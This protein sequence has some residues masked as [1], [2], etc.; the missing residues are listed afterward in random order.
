LVIGTSKYKRI[1]GKKPRWKYPHNRA[2]SSPPR[3]RL[4]LV[5]RALKK[6]ERRR[7]GSSLLDF[8]LRLVP[9]AGVDDVRRVGMICL[10]VFFSVCRYW[11]M[12][13]NL[14]TENNKM[15]VGS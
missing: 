5:R 13:D 7:R 10:F 1:N 14:Q 2:E 6:D 8:L 9:A 4:C 12:Y 3:C 15:F 11:A